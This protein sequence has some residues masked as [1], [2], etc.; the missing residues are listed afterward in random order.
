[1]LF[2]NIKWLTKAIKEWPTLSTEDCE[3][4]KLLVDRLVS[5]VSAAA[6]NSSA[7]NSYSWHWGHTKVRRF[8]GKV[9]GE[10][11]FV[12]RCCDRVLPSVATSDLAEDI[13]TSCEDSYSTCAGCDDNCYT[14]DM[15]TFASNQYCESCYH[16]HF[17]SCYD[18]GDVFSREDLLYNENGEEY[19][20]SCDPGEGEEEE[21]EE[22]Q[23]INFPRRAGSDVRVREYSADVCRVY[24]GPWLSA[25]GEATDV[26]GNKRSKTPTLWLGFELE[27]VSRVEPSPAPRRPYD[28]RVTEMCVA[29][30][31][32]GILKQDGS[33]PGEGFEIV[34]LPG[35]IQYHQT[36]W[37]DEFFQPLL[38]N[39]RGWGVTGVGMHVHLARAALTHLQIGRLTFFVN[40]ETNRPFIE[41]IAGRSAT[42]YSTIQKKKITS[43]RRSDYDTRGGRG[44]SYGMHDSD[45][46]RYQAVNLIKKD[47]VEI[48]IFQSNVSQIGF[49]KN[50][51]FCD[52]AANFCRTASNTQLD[53]AHFLAWMDAHR[54][55]YPN[56]TKWAVREGLLTARH[57]A[58]PGKAEVAIAA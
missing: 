36:Q 48:R 24:P 16:D 39:C 43:V 53:K 28:Q 40:D 4:Y 9:T 49:L 23:S 50:I 52:G 32:R 1:M 41:K 6:P 56:F 20:S 54:G 19:C 21:E 26:R 2:S 33:I 22:A 55:T 51:E 42:R 46:G 38:E 7:P 30:G 31:H 34:S 10:D 47:T 17:G 18:C 13:C 25:P 29:L 8:L 11:M 27:V 45:E 35:T 37:G 14:D 58:Q 5:D 57:T 12:T 3:K 44:L 15:S